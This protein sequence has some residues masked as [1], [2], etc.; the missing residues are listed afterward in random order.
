METP[1]PETLRRELLLEQAISRQFDPLLQQVTR[2]TLKLEGNRD[3]EVNQLRNLL[4]VAVESR[5][6]EVVINFIRYQIARNSRA[7]GIGKDDFGHQVITDLR[8]SVKEL[9]EA[10]MTYLRATAGDTPAVHA[11]EPQVYLRL[12]QLYLGYLNRTFYFAR[13]VNSFDWLKEVH[14]AANAN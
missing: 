4:S 13:R 12:M 14:H 10:A 1:D 7:W 9:A 8:G 2:T 5:S 6:V 3:M 11:L